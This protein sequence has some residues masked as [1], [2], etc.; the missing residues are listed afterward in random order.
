MRYVGVGSFHTGGLDSATKFLYVINVTI[1]DAPYQFFLSGRFVC[2]C[3][4]L[5]LINLLYVPTDVS[6]LNVIRR[7]D[8]HNVAIFFL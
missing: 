3:T 6:F 1:S 5:F 7:C 4:R 2:V 8:K